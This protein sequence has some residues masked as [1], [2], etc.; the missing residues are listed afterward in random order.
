MLEP[1][2]LNVGD[3]VTVARYR[4]FGGVS[5]QGIYDV[6]KVD[7]MKVV[8]RRE[9]DGYERVFSVKTGIEKGSSRYKSA[10]IES[11]EDNDEREVQRA[12]LAKLNESWTNV[13]NAAGRKNL[14]DLELA[15]AALKTT[16]EA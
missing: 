4:N 5:L 12:Q 15:V 3:K 16:M 1:R 10:I 14:K 7:K 8:L 13:Q 11:L 6:V 2:E 9:S